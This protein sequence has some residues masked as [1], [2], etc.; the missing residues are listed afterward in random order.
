MGFKKNIYLVVKNAKNEQTTNKSTLAK[1]KRRMRRNLQDPE[2]PSEE[3]RS[4]SDMAQRQRPIVS[5][6]MHALL[7]PSRTAGMSPIGG[8][9]RLLMAGL[10]E[11]KNKTRAVP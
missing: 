1:T 3:E 9:A 2:D 11:R 8:F 10:L 6:K 4:S 5:G 7:E